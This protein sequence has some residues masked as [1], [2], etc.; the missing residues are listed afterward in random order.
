MFIYRLGQQ[1]HENLSLRQQLDTLRLNAGSLPGSDTNEKLNNILTSLRAESDRVNIVIKI[2]L[3]K[4][5]Q[6]DITIFVK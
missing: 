5:S 4:R 3:K 1:Q 6:A 2:G